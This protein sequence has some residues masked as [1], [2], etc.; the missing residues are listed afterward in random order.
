ML[1]Q[2]QKYLSLF[3]LNVLN[4]NPEEGSTPLP[5]NSKLLVYPCCYSNGGTALTLAVELNSLKK[6][7]VGLTVP[8]DK[9]F[10]KE[11][12]PTNP[13]ILKELIVTEAVT[14]SVSSVDDKISLPVSVEYTMKTGKTGESLE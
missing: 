12:D 7:N 9:N 6:R 13:P 10:V 3:H 4:H 2:E 5:S 1:H 14:G 11:H 8:M